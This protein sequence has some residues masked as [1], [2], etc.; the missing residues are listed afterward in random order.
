VDFLG[1]EQQEQWLLDNLKI[2]MND[3]IYLSYISH[4]FMS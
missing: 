1:K 3:Q 4:S 2:L